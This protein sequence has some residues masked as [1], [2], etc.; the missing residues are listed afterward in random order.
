MPRQPNASKRTPAGLPRPAAP[1]A[2]YSGTPLPKKLGIKPGFVVVLDGAPE[3]FEHTLGELPDGATV[4]RNLR[5]KRHLTL[6]FVRSTAELRRCIARKKSFGAD[7]GLW[8]CWPKKASGVITDVNETVVRETALANGLVDF[9]VA[10]IDATWSGH[11][12][13]LRQLPG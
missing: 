12:F 8:I 3:G 6:W 11:R 5:A 1:P 13:N 2:G 9:K 4:C 10:A 7:S